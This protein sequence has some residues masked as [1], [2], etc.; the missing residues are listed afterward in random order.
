MQ[1]T[2][3]SIAT[4]GN[5]QSSER[6]RIAPAFRGYYDAVLG[7]RNYWY[8]ALFVAELGD[9][10]IKVTMLGENILIK[11][12]D[13]KVY[14]IEDRCAHRLV[15]L[16]KK[17]ECHSKNTITCWYHGWT[18]NWKDGTINTIITEPN[19]A[20][21]GKPGVKSYPVEV[22]KGLVFVYIGDGEPRKLS[23]NL[24][25]GFVEPDRVMHGIRRVVDSNWRWG[26]ENGFDST[27]IYI[28]RNSKLLQMTEAKIPLGLVPAG[29]MVVENYDKHDPIGVRESTLENFTPVFS[30]Q[31]ED[32]TI[33]ARRNPPG[34]V[35]PDGPPPVSAGSIWMPGVLQIE[36]AVIP[37]QNQYEFYV[38]IDEKRH[39]YFQLLGKTCKT[40]EEATEH[41]RLVDE[42][43]TDLQ[44]HGFNDDDVWAR[45]AMEDA[46]TNGH[47]WT[48]ER[49]FKPDMATT[50]W[51]KMAS[52]HHRGIQKRG[53]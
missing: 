45:E 8:P 12:I 3:K 39:M 42:V 33:S 10:P 5:A 47:G 40:E 27:H 34:W 2:D 24:P 19:S 51:R 52:K 16:S 13:D 4:D 38:P 22:Y 29:R 43:W 21:I 28:H 7:F 14:A 30:S 48:R 41:V 35:A 1:T 9:E 26:C 11:K 18:F 17:I 44:L 6:E 50:E 32:V 36:T 49:L 20:L 25:P 31:I 37:H 15:P 23:D 46:Y 53:A